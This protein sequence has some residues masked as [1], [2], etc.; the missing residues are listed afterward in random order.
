MI[1]FLTS[2][3]WRKPWPYLQTSRDK[4]IVV[5][6]VS[7]YTPLFLITFQPF[8]VNNYDQTHTIG[9]TFALSALG[10]GLMNGLT[11]ASYE[12]VVV[13]LIFKSN[14]PAVLVLR[15]AGELVF[16]AST[17]FLFYNVLGNFH[18][19][20]VTSYIGFIRDVSAMSILPLLGLGLY[21]KYRQTKKALQTV[22]EPQ[23]DPKHRLI[24]LQ[25]SHGKNRLGIVISRL[26][27]IE[28]QDN[29]VAIHYLQQ[30]QV[31]K[32]LLRTPLKRLESELIKHGVYRCHRSF[33]VNFNRIESVKRNHHQLHLYLTQ[34][35]KPIPVS[36]QYV[37]IVQP[38]LAVHRK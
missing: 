38:K 31:I 16:L 9:F 30:N 11:I 19:W 4:W 2:H 25:P 1:P 32:S 18:D 34:L 7:L 3:S 28:A 13:P 6:A 23:T 27:F 33:L 35:D 10:F 29:Y 36:R 15:I 17:T 5:L 37:P 22:L 21:F 26:L 14:Q 20:H 8:G 12:F 24:W